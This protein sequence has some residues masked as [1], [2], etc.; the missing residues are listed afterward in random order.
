MRKAKPPHQQKEK[1]T[2]RIDPSTALFIGERAFQRN[3]TEAKFCAWLVA[4]GAR[5]LLADEAYERR[6]EGYEKRS[7]RRYGVDV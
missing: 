5:A 3:W 1:I 2:I 6:V 4:R 7:L